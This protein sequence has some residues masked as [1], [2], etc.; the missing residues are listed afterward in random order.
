MQNKKGKLS[1]HSENIFPIIKKWLYSDHDI[2][3]RELI[4][5]ASD[6]ITK[7]KRLVSVGEANASD[8][9][10]RIDVRYD[11]E[12]EILHIEDNGLGMTADE[13][14]EY[15]NK[16][17]FSGAE[18]FV[19]RFKDKTDEEQI[20]GH[21]GLGFYSAFMV[22]EK[23][24]IDTLSYKEGSEPAF[25]SC[26]G[27]TDFD[28]RTGTRTERG[29][30]ISLHF[31][32]DGKDFKNEYK[33]KNTIHKYCSFMPYPIYFETLEKD[34]PETDSE[35]EEKKEVKQ[36][37][38]TKPLY[39]ENPSSLTDEDYKNFYRDTFVDFKEP[40]FWIHLN[41]DY[42][43]RLKGILFFPKLSSDFGELD[44]VIKLYNSQVY[45]AD[46]IKEVIPEFLMLLKG[47]IDC[48]DLPLNVSRS[49]LQNDG[50]VKKISDYIT[51]KVSDKLV[52]LFKTDR[53]NYEKYWD[54]IHVFIKYGILKEAKFYDKIK[55]A[56]LYQTVEGGHKTLG[57]ITKGSEE[58]SVYYT[59]DPNA[60]SKYIELLNSE[61]RDILIMK[62]RIDPAFIGFIEGDNDK[63]KFKRVD[64]DISELLEDGETPPDLSPKFDDEKNG[65]EDSEDSKK[66][67]FEYLGKEF[68]DAVGI[69]NIKVDVKRFKTKN[70]AAIMV[71]SEE[72][73]RM[74]E[75]MKLY[76]GTAGMPEF[77]TEEVL[78][79]NRS[80]ELVSTLLDKDLDE[81][82]KNMLMNQFYDLAK[83]S[84][85]QLSGERMKAFVKRTQDIMLSYLK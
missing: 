46:N 34:S 70:M 5:N 21:F 18:D 7:M 75:L 3:V 67:E 73:R 23:V 64:S 71:L 53:E 26:D 84:N 56:I 16:I 55:E 22:A 60:Q 63:V 77:P 58:T 81:D 30:T 48:P 68:S 28:M 69:E 9:D 27:G 83:L 36:V 31:S 49:F 62:E 35:A 59:D 24:T 12:K 33:I 45:V 37:N 41:M 1:I 65:E 10:Y 29:T 19:K 52:G 44:G 32:E 6:A 61:D 39:L 47:V 38:V 54:D 76:S 13:I 2:F 57:E 51:K 79:L 8:D 40:L 11:K 74:A 80:N 82:K 50:F 78:V 15:I 25:W 66:P 17:A 20:I 43:F 4:S 85:M 14:E 72:S 42:P